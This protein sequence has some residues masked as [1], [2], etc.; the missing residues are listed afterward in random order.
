MI[1]ISRNRRELIVRLSAEFAIVVLGVTIALWADGWVASQRDRVEERER[2]QALQYNIA[3]TLE[4]LQEERRSADGAA[5]ALRDLLAPQDISNESARAVLRYALLYGAVF[6][7]ELNVYDDL[8]NSGELALLTD[9]EVRRTLA[10]MDSSLRVL[11]LAQ[12]D[13]ASVQLLDID[14][15]VIDSTNLRI[16]YGDGLGLDWI[17]IDF[18]RDLNFLTDI[19][20]QNRIVLKLDLVTQLSMRLD[21]AEKALEDTDKAIARQLANY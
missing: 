9:P 17:P 16:L 11:K 12:S 20:F 13:L 3:E 18:E 10:K 1:S 4:N 21:G 7:P 8:K 5:N 2:L 15:Y 19:R 6:V 14:S